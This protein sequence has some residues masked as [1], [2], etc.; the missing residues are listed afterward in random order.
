MPTKCVYRVTEPLDIANFCLGH[1]ASYNLKILHANLKLSEMIR[2]FF[3]FKKKTYTHTHA[4]KETEF[5]L[6]WNNG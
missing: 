6:I 2:L 1:L 3:L 5:L 4:P